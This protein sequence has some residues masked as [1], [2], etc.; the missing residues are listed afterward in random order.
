MSRI[1]DLP[2]GRKQDKVFT[3][4][5]FQWMTALLPGS[6]TADDDKRLEALFSE[7]VRHPGASRLAHSSAVQVDLLLFRNVFHRFPQPIGF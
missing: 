1:V 7:Q 2:K 6:Q 4:D 3:R 5:W